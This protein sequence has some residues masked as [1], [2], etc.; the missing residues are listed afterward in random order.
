M[1][2][3]GPP[4]QGKSSIDD[5]SKKILG[6]ETENEVNSIKIHIHGKFFVYLELGDRFKLALDA[7][8][9]VISKKGLGIVSGII[10]LAIWLIKRFWP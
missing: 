4:E 1:S 3:H 6:I 2:E 7:P 10:G 8:I 5:L 9:F